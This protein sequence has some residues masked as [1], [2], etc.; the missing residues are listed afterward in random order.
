MAVPIAMVT[1][2]SPHARQRARTPWRDVEYLAIDLETSGLDL[3][4]DEILSYGFVV[5]RHGRVI[6]A[7][8]EQALV[9]PGRPVPPESTKIHSLRTADLVAGQTIEVA[10]K[11]IGEAAADRIL[12]AHAAWIER[13]FL[14]RAFATVGRPFSPTFID[15]A[16]LARAV[17]WA[18][19]AREREPSLE[20][21]CREHRLPVHTPHEALGDAL[22][23]AG[24]FLAEASLLASQHPGSLKVRDLVKLSRR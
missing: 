24:L 11:I 22:T 9:R 4:R 15:T 10:V 13:A 3:E 20:W 23:T 8:S 18:D 19:S 2:F 21:L 16:G 1:F 14:T 12:V 7:S 6:A 17:G 5:V